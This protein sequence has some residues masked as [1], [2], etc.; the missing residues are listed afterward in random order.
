MK[1][2]METQTVRVQRIWLYVAYVSIGVHIIKGVV[3]VG[4]ALR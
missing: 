1:W 3:A 4:M 2:L